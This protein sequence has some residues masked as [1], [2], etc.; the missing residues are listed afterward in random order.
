MRKTTF[1]LVFIS[2]ISGCSTENF[3]NYLSFATRPNCGSY[4]T[5]DER[6]RCMKESDRSYDSYEKER[7]AI[8]R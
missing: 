3:Y 8:R 2:A 1:L 7:S 4:N 5:T 6:S